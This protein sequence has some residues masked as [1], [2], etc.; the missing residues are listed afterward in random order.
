VVPRSAR[1]A[2]VG[3]RRHK[4]AGK[5]AQE[6]ATWRISGRYSR[7]SPRLVQSKFEDL[8]HRPAQPRRQPPWRQIA[9]KTQGLPRGKKARRTCQSA[10]AAFVAPTEPARSAADQ[11]TKPGEI[12]MQSVRFSHMNETRATAR[13]RSPAKS[14]ARR[15]PSFLR[16]VG[17]SRRVP[18]DRRALTG[19]GRPHF[20]GLVVALNQ[21]QLDLHLPIYSNRKQ[22][23]ASGR[24][25]RTSEDR[26]E[27]G[28]RSERST[29]ANLHSRRRVGTASVP[30]E[31]QWRFR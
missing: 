10:S 20:V 30:L 5:R 31:L 18:G 29:R 6:Q 27:T 15:Q 26:R 14:A 13:P 22:S 16:Q 17:R 25:R 4:R 23:V 7:H 28:A 11:R 12:T 1:P 21:P 2:A 24:A 9:G 19:R 8:A 3:S